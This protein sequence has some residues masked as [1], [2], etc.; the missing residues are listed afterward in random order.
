MAQRREEEEKEK[1]RRNGRTKIRGAFYCG[2]A[3]GDPLVSPPPS[4]DSKSTS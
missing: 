3:G 2:F 1:E 4:P